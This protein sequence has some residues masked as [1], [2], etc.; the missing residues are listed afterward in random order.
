MHRHDI[1][2]GKR[3][4]NR[5]QI[6][7]VDQVAVQAL[8]SSPKLAIALH[9]PLRRR[10]RYGVKVRRQGADFLNLRRRPNQKIFILAVEPPQRANHITDVRTYA[11]LSHPPDVDRDLHRWHLNT[12]GTDVHTGITLAPPPVPSP[13]VPH[14]AETPRI[15]QAPAGGLSSA[16]PHL[17]AAATLRRSSGRSAASRVLSCRAWSEPANQCGCRSASSEDWCRTGSRSC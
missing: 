5:K 17:F 4:W 6:R 8:Q 11:K 14:R 13:V 1:A 16:L 7:N 10:Q 3:T 2:A 9:R 12:A 15:D